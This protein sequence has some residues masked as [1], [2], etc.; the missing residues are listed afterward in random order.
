MEGNS[1]ECS[2]VVISVVDI[3]DKINA[4]ETS[5]ANFSEKDIKIPTE[6]SEYRVLA[7][8]KRLLD[9]KDAVEH[10]VKS[11]PSDHNDE[12]VAITTNTTEEDPNKN[13]AP[14]GGW[15]WFVVLGSAL[16]H[17]LLGGFER[18]S[19]V[20]FLEL[21]DRFGQSASAT[22]W[23]SAIFSTSRF[24]MSPV[25]SA[26]CH[27]FTIRFVV[28]IGSLLFA[29]GVLVTGYAPNLTIVYILFGLLGGFGSSLVYVPSLIIV[30]QYFN[31][32]RGLAIGLSSAGV[33]LG[34]LFIPPL[35]GILFDH[36]G[37]QGACL[38]LS[39]IIL[40]S[41]IAAFL[42][43]PVV[44]VRSLISQT[45]KEQKNDN[46]HAEQELLLQTDKPEFD[47][48][49][50]KPELC[51]IKTMTPEKENDIPVIG[52]NSENVKSNKE[53]LQNH[54]QKSKLAKSIQ[55]G[56]TF[57]A[58]KNLE[59]HRKKPLVELSLLK[60]M[61]F[62]SL[63][64]AIS[65]FTMAF[66]ITFVFLPPLIK[67]RGMTE[68]DAAYIVSIT[69]VMDGV[70][71]VLAGFILDLNSI[72]K[73]RLLIYNGIMIVVGTV[74]LLIPSIST[75]TG[76]ALLCAF[77]GIMI[78]AY[79]S[80]KSIVIIDILGVD[81]MTSSLGLLLWFQGVGTLAGP[82]L[83]GFLRDVFGIYDGAFYLGGSGMI[84]GALILLAGNVWKLCRDAR[85]KDIA[86]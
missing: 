60:N 42:F 67:D 50:S 34:T 24:M 77:Y 75:F 10:S 6:G 37:F 73:Y 81:K 33:G 52:R 48:N 40:N 62:L 29:L 13:S 72:K 74:S 69:G 30:S 28:F 20:L 64:I 22:A 38:I 41:V 9:R 55:L 86:T 12:D 44:P 39:G 61:T 32:K 45:R 46:I 43:R 21:K 7:D 47:A 31:K 65:F 66:H 71:K 57:I 79:I 58:I 25:A 5:E 18:S 36:Y 84:F 82:P 8:D 16:I 54:R 15:G 63:C 56:K 26:M 83:S 59:P 11:T 19:G 14:D 51:C 1:C 70:G 23:V 78:G 3:T 27:R 49:S 68:L 35:F 80:Q 53:N 4:Q 76:F 2:K 85:S 17:I